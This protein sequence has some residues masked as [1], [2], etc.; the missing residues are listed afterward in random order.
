MGIVA[1]AA[2]AASGG[3]AAAGGNDYRHSTADQIGGQR[4]QAI[5]L[6]LCPAKFNCHVAAF[7]V[8]GLLKALAERGDEVREP[9]RCSAAEIPDFGHHPLLRADH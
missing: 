7:G 5:V 9:G 8:A 6:T 2:F 1:V 3:L 4:R